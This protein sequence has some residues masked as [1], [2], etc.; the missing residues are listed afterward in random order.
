MKCN[1]VGCGKID[2]GFEDGICLPCYQFITAVEDQGKEHMSERTKAQFEQHEKQFK[3][4]QKPM[5]DKLFES[6]MLIYGKDLVAATVTVL[7][8]DGDSFR[9]ISTTVPQK[10]EK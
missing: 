8:K 10:Q 7:L 2:G 6:L 4:N 3:K 9:Y 5:T 1:I